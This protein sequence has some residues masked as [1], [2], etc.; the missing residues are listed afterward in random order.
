MRCGLCGWAAVVVFLVFG[1]RLMDGLLNSIRVNSENMFCGGIA[2]C[3]S[4]IT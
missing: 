4:S 2:F 1:I 3:F